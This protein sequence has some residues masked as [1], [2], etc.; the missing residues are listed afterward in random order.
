MRTAGF[1]DQI[2][3][4]KGFKAGEMIEQEDIALLHGVIV[5]TIVLVQFYIELQ[6]F[7]CAAESADTEIIDSGIDDRIFRSNGHLL[8]TCIGLNDGTCL[9]LALSAG[10]SSVLTCHANSP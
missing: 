8:T 9:L 7:T 6:Q 5:N 1:V 2:L 3:G 10:E 4:N